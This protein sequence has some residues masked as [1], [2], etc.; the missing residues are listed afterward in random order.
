MLSI[1]Q[2]FDK[3][4]NFYNQDKFDKAI[5]EFENIAKDDMLY[6]LSLCFIGICNFYMGYYN[7]SAIS[8]SNAIEICKTFKEINKTTEEMNFQK[9][10]KRDLTVLLEDGYLH[11]YYFLTQ[12]KLEKYEDAIQCFDQNIQLSESNEY[13]KNKRLSYGLA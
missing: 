10:V 1:G 9:N 5:Q 12:V 8:F 13:I 6:G 3:G 11:Y 7:R 2:Y 4:L